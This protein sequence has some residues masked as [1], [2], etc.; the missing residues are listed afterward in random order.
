MDRVLV[1][2]Y[3]ELDVV[4]E[5]EQSTREFGV[6]VIAV[7]SDDLSPRHGR[8]DAPERLDR[9]RRVGGQRDCVHPLRV[10]VCLR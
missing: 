6:K 1:A 9:A 10:T 3:E 5:A 2:V 7:S 4:H 8:D